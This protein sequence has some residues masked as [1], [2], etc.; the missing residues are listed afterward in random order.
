[1]HGSRLTFSPISAAKV[2]NT[3]PCPTYNDGWNFFVVHIRAIT[4][5]NSSYQQVYGNDLYCIAVAGTIHGVDYITRQVL[6]S[7]TQEC[8]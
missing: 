8:I 4:A 6:E 2:F 5:L 3:E 1:M 7:I